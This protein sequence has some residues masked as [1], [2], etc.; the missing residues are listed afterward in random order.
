M[1]G[2]LTCQDCGH[3]I[4]FE[5]AERH[6]ASMTVVEPG[7]PKCSSPITYNRNEGGI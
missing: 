1:K 3:E 7:C 4:D 2:D 5:T 6:E